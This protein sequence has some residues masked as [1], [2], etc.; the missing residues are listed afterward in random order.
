MKILKTEGFQKELKAILAYIAQDKIGASR[1]FRADLNA[2]IA[3]LSDFPY[4]Y[5]KSIYFDSENIR[6]M[7]FKKHTIT[8]EIDLKEKTIF[9]LSIF[10]QNKP[11]S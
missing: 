8:Y 10:K 5:K 1:N 11:P 7:T 9:I 4:K 2:H 3:N 6:D